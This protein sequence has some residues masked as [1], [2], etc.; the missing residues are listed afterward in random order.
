MTMP[1]TRKARLSL[2]RAM[3]LRR[4]S[5]SSSRARTTSA[6]DDPDWPSRPDRHPARPTIVWP[7]IARL[8]RT[9]KR[10]ARS[11]CTV[12]DL[13]PRPTDHMII[14]WN[15]RQ[16]VLACDVEESI[17]KIADLDL[18]TDDFQNFTGTSLSQDTPV[19]RLYDGSISS[20]YVKLLKDRQ[21][22]ARQTYSPWRR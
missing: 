12:R 6:I 17:K 13:C 11:R 20:F 4:W 21:T 15:K 9:R 14:M 16:N 10:V 7:M 1:S 18:D 3:R 22:N 19:V 5:G 2:A 8:V